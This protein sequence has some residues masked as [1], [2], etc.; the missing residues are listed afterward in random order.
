ME[1]YHLVPM[2]DDKNIMYG[3]SKKRSIMMDYGLISYKDAKI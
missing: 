3:H 1:N 2:D